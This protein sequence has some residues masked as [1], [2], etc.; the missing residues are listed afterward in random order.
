M[1]MD[2]SKVPAAEAAAA[3]PKPPP[4]LCLSGWRLG[5]FMAA[6]VAWTVFIIN[7]SIFLW[8]WSRSPING[9]N[10]VVFQ[11]SCKTSNALDIL[12]HLLINIFSTCL[13]GASNY[14]MQC[15]NAPTRDEVG[16]AHSE[17]KW[18]DIGVPSFRNL[19]FMTKS[20]LLMWSLLALSSIPLHLLYNSVVFKTSQANQYSAA[21][22]SQDF[23]AGA[24][25]I[26]PCNDTDM[27]LQDPWFWY[28]SASECQAQFE[29]FIPSLLGRVQLNSSSF[30]KLTASDCIEAYDANF[31]TGRSDVVLV[32]TAHNANNSILFS[33][34][35][36][37]YL[38]GDTPTT[39][40]YQWMCY[41]NTSDF[42]DPCDIPSPNEASTWN[43]K[44][45]IRS[46]IV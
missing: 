1:R 34:S 42:S 2:Y 28:E 38:V 22:V 32:S 26:S 33:Q 17:K 18:V 23:W 20:K 29:R 37:P 4:N 35:P 14:C 6:S 21:L 31:E 44:V 45:V 10:G 8:M 25:W 5:S 3:D 12:I 43:I 13:L 19:S 40:H 30:Q 15:L 27:P 24:P 46:I 41:S 9:G 11:G 7:I 16:K 36:D 39:E